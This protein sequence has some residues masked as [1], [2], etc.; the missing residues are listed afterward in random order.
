M[1]AEAESRLFISDDGIWCDRSRPVSGEDGRGENGE[2]LYEECEPVQ[3]CDD[4]QA[5]IEMLKTAYHDEAQT[6]T[7]LR[8]ENDKLR[9]RGT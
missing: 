4:L 2:Q 9:A 3:V 1:S 5:E 7:A 8:Q 6:N